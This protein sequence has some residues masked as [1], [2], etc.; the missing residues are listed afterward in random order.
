LIP[1]KIML[2]TFSAALLM[3]AT[4]ATIQDA[5]GAVTT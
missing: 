3:A 5:P 4:N 2:K 1:N